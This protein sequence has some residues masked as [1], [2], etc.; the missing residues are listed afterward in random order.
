MNSGLAP[1]FR[2]KPFTVE[3]G[4]SCSLHLMDFIMLRCFLY[5]Q[6]IEIVM[7]GCYILSNAFSGSIEIIMIFIFPSVNVVLSYLAICVC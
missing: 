1:N 5:T 2:R 4:I 6:F 3:Y 7:K